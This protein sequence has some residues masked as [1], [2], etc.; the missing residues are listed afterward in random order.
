MK[1]FL[2]FLLK[3]WAFLK[4]IPVF[5]LLKL[6]VCAV[7]RPASFVILRFLLVSVREAFRPI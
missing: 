6:T 7:V 3:F 4:P 5:I 2:N 1:P